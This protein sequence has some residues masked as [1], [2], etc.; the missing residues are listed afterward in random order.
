[1]HRS[2]SA[3]AVPPILPLHRPSRPCSAPRRTFRSPPPTRSA[4]LSRERCRSAEP[5]GRWGGG[6]CDYTRLDAVELPDDATT[7]LAR[8]EIASM[9]ELS[10]EGVTLSSWIDAMVREDDAAW[11][12]LVEPAGEPPPIEP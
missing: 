3:N 12:D 11:R 10:I 7:L 1:M 2:V 6:L 9:Y 4:T 5:L 8:V